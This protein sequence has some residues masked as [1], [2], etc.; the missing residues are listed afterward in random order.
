MF[1][2]SGCKIIEFHQQTCWT[3]ITSD[4]KKWQWL[5]VITALSVSRITQIVNVKKKLFLSTYGLQVFLIVFK[6]LT[7][8]RFLPPPPHTQI[9]GI[10]IIKWGW[11]FMHNPSEG[12][13]TAGS[14]P[15]QWCSNPFTLYQ[16][17]TKLK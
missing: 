12:P 11:F 6:V 16:M 5:G 3:K 13:N 14:L 8:V 15:V 17:K 4:Y 10:N 2:C 1:W 7:E 9:F